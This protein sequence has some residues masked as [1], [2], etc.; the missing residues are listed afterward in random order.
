MNAPAEMHA[1]LIVTIDGPAGTGKSSVARDL[2]RRLGLEFL[3]TGAMY[4]AAALTVIEQGLS[5]EDASSVAKA[6]RDAEIHFEWDTDP[7]TLFASGEPRTDRLRDADVSSLVSP[8]S[9]LPEVRGVLVEKQ[10]RIGEIHPRLVSEGRDQGSVV[11]PDADVKF[12]LDASVEVRTERRVEQLRALGRSPSES[13]VR[14]EIIDRDRRDSTRAVG[15]LV[16]P[17]DAVRVLTDDHSQDEVVERLAEEV[18]SR[19]GSAR[20]AAAS[21]IG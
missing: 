21:R 12:Y 10:R 15:P 4:R 11:F 7:P 2:A 13:D 14:Q 18:E 19:V 16:C 6:V 17:D 5:L 3:D 1:R 20:L 8:V 9:K